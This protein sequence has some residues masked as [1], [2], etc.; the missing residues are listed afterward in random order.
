VSKFQAGWHASLYASGF[1]TR[2]IPSWVVNSNRR[3]RR[4]EATAA[5]ATRSVGNIVKDLIVLIKGRLNYN[6]RLKSES[7]V[8]KVGVDEDEIQ[9]CWTGYAGL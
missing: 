1:P 2:L 3:S 9:D 7:T 6:K 8:G 4:A 5:E